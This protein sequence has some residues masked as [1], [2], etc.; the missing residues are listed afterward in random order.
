M[1]SIP[2]L[3]GATLTVLTLVSTHA[4]E[5]PAAGVSVE[6]RLQSI[7]QDTG[8]KDAAIKAGKKVASFC[9][10]CHGNGGTSILPEIPNLA[11]QNPAYLLVQVD[12]FKDGRRRN[13]FMQGMIK[14]LSDEEKV[15]VVVYYSHQEV[16]PHSSSDSA[17]AKRGGELY[18]KI[19]Q[20]CHGEQGRGNEKIARIA[21]QQ[22]VYLTSTLKHYRD[23]TGERTD[24]LMSANTKKLTDADIGA[25]VAYVSSMK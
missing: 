15:S 18:F 24:P 3:V 4:A 2:L 12:K 20:R 11:G 14:A 10:N 1:K 23:G 17:Q 13:D 22:S 16:K 6:Q 21:G 19:C 25:L 9:A 8:Q 7:M 5:K